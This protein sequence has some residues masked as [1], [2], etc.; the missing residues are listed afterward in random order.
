[1][2]FVTIG[3]AVVVGIVAGLAIALFA[4]SN[5]FRDKDTMTFK[6]K[7]GKPVVQPKTAHLY[8]PGGELTF[9]NEL[10]GAIDIQFKVKG[11]K[12]G[13]FPKS[14]NDQE[15]GKINVNSDGNSG[16]RAV[17]VNPGTFTDHWK[18]DAYF[19]G[20]KIDPGVKVR[21]S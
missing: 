18:F 2:D 16:P 11:G 8:Y 4:S 10:D 3:G 7:N 21:N 1:M 19:N 9:V 6:M 15:R 17:D 20:E 12:K 13:P 14:P 5:H